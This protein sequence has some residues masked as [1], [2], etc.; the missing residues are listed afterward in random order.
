M[1]ANTYLPSTNLG[2]TISGSRL[3]EKYLPAIVVMVID[4]FMVGLGLWQAYYIRFELNPAWF[5][6]NEVPAFGFYRNLAFVL[7]ALWLVVFRLFGL[8]DGKHLFSGVY[9]YGQVFNACTLGVMMVIFYSFLDPTFIVARAWIALAWLLVSVEVILG[10]FI[11]RRAVQ[12]LRKQGYLMTQAVMVGANAEGEA[13]AHQLYGN[14]KTGINLVGFIDNKME[15]GKEVLP[16]VPVLGNLSA[17]Q[18][19]IKRYG[20]KELIVSSTALSRHELLD[21]FQAFG[22]AENVT[23][24]LSSGLYEMIT[25]GVEVQDVGNVPL[26]S[27]NKARLTGN[28]V[29]MKRILDIVGSLAA[30]F[31][32]LPFMVVIAIAVAIDSPGPI[33]HKRRVVG[34]GGTP[35]DAFK[36]R[37]MYI[38]GNERLARHPELQRELEETQK[39]KN[40]PR[41]TRVGK[42]IRRTSMDEIPQF[43]NVLRGEMSLVGPRMITETERAMY[44]KWRTN[45]VTVKPGITGLWQ[46]SG[47]SDVSY[48]QRVALDMQ[49]IRNYSIWFDIYLLWQTIPAVLQKRGAY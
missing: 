8:Y 33:F 7:I 25:T 3:A 27:L 34:A 35:F 45:L 49:Y 18:S 1:N 29:L 30:L 2:Q 40:D 21:L 48:E 46:V 17:I 38:D 23:I 14:Y 10:R 28:E 24:R 20:V 12:E 42:F 39:I 6:Q 31:M 22:V 15:K 47:R 37:S 26:M 11:F 36:F 4:A 16:G 13:I 32:F 19:I 9:E 44:G 43:F 41:V 5:Y